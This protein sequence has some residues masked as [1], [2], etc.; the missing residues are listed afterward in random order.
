MNTLFMMIGIPGSGKTTLANRLKTEKCRVISSDEIRKELGCLTDMSRNK[1][2]FNI[3]RERLRDEIQL[4]DVI[5]DCTNITKSSRAKTLEGLNC[6]KVAIFLN[7][8]ID[9]CKNNNRNREN[10]IPEGIIE[11]MHNSI[12]EPSYDE[13]FN[14]IITFIK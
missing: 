8:D 1:E 2:V 13:G 5:L 14:S 9:T 6:L 4:H 3:L 12:E 11:G 10:I 7:K